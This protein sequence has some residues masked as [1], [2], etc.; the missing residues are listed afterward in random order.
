MNNTFRYTFLPILTFQGLQFGTLLGGAVITE[1]E[2][3][4]P[5]PGLLL[6]DA[7]LIRGYPVVQATVWVV[8][9]IYVLVILA[10]DLVYHVVDPR[11]RWP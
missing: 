11:L 6:L 7:I 5:P 4:W 1:I 3:A 8:C 10:I 9:S 2:F